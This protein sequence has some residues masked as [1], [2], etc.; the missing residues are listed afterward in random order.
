MQELR[1]GRVNQPNQQQV[2]SMLIRALILRFFGTIDLL[3]ASLLW[4]AGLALVLYTLPGIAVFLLKGTVAYVFWLLA[5]AYVGLMVLV[6]PGLIIAAIG[7]GLGGWVLTLIARGYLQIAIRFL[8]WLRINYW[9][10]QEDVALN[11][12]S[13]SNQHN[14]YQHQQMQQPHKPFSAP[15]APPQESPVPWTQRRFRH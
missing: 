2:A 14:A 7:F 13:G 8:N 6:L 15:I 1:R 11:N 10:A 4:S 3:W 12:F 9:L 5:A